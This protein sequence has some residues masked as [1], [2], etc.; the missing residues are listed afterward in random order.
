MNEEVY[1]AFRAQN[2]YAKFSDF[3]EN[4]TGWEEFSCSECDVEVDDCIQ[5]EGDE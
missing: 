3:L 5:E 4:Y 2:K 1:T